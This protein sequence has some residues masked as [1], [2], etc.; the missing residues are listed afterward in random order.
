MT[1]FQDLDNELV[2]GCDEA[3]SFYSYKVAAKQK[4]I[5]VNIFDSLAVV[6]IKNF[7]MLICF[8]KNV[9]IELT[10]PVPSLNQNANQ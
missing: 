5:P 6:T 8:L 1:C 10:L 3:L 7:Q 4:N 2:W 9:L